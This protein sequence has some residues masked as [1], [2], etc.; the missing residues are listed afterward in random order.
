M[1]A[2]VTVTVMALLVS[3][4]A[5]SSLVLTGNIDARTRGSDNAVAGNPGGESAG[6]RIYTAVCGP[7]A[8][9]ACQTI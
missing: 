4:I 6:S 5:V 2:I 3:I 9:L 1:R 8:A 7:G